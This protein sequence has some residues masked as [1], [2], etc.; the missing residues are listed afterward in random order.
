V[1]VFGLGS[2]TSGIL[3]RWAATDS[4]PGVNLLEDLAEAPLEL[5]RET[6]RL[7]KRP[8]DIVVASIHWGSNWGYAVPEE[9]V[10]FAHGLVRA[11][12]DVVH[13]HSSHHVRPMEIFEG[14]LILYGCG[15]FLDDYE[16]IP[17]EGGFRSDLT[18]MY[19]PTI[20]P[21]RGQLSDLLMTPMRIKNFRAN[22]ASV[23]EARWLRDTIDRESRDFGVRVGLRDGRLAL[24]G[25]PRLD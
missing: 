13:G 3:S 12:A 8:R 15:D 9:H 5:L 6:I 18:L 25:L 24:L 20:D 1:L 19:F 23:Q 4:E 16:G 14:K 17:G 7:V 10:R 11:G 22:R 21:I 2:A